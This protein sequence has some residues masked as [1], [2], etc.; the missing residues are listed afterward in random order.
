MGD[1][2]DSMLQAGL[3]EAVAQQQ[4]RAAF[5]RL[6]AFYAPRLLA[7]FQKRGADSG[8]AQDL[9]QDVML[10]LW[11]K[12]ALYSPDKAKVSTWLFRIARNRHIDWQRAQPRFEPAPE[13][14]LD[15]KPSETP[16]PEAQVLAWED[17][18]RVQAALARL[19][20]EQYAV[21]RLA[22]FDALSHSAI[23]SE[24]ALPLGTVK[25]RIRLGLR[26]MKSTLEASQCPT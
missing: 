9:V 15:A 12:A 6:Y 23:A 13:T 5:A 26:R 18:A 4:D 10:T 24:L 16:S 7:F 25:S 1:D 2:A 8:Q 14:E 19:P 3:V 21:L 11:R 17:E 22:V 20:E